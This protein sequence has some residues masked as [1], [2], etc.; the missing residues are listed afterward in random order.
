MTGVTAAWWESQRLP[1]LLVCC[2]LV[3]VPH[4]VGCWMRGGMCVMYMNMFVIMVAG[5]VAG[6]PAEPQRKCGLDL[7]DMSM[8]G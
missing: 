5:D 2:W 4:P 8:H 3:V 1:L 6:G 7:P